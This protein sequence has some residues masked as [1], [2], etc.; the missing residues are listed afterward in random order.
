AILP[1]LTTT[2]DLADYTI[3]FAPI[4]VAVRPLRLTANG[5]NFTG[6]SIRLTMHYIEIIP[7]TS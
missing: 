1:A 6:G 4:Y 7:P 5:G 3:A 2:T